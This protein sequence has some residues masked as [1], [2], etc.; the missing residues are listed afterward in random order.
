MLIFSI[1]LPLNSAKKETMTS[2]V[3][4]TLPIYLGCI[5]ILIVVGV[6]VTLYFLLKGK[7]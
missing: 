4:M 7:I 2:E 6:I 5:S 3:F 1:P